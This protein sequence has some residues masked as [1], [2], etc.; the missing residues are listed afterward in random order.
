MTRTVSERSGTSYMFF[1]NLQLVSDTLLM[2]TK[3]ENWP[4]VIRRSISP[5]TSFKSGTNIK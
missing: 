3:Y 5:E 4:T 1:S 2:R